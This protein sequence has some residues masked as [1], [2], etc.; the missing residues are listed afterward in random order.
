VLLLFVLIG[1]MILSNLLIILC[2]MK[3]LKKNAY[4][5]ISR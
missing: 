2:K 3:S 1:G 5:R 4:T